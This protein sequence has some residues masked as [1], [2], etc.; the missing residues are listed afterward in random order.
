MNIYRERVSKIALAPYLSYA[1]GWVMRVWREE[2]V[3]TSD[4][5][6]TRPADDILRTI[7]RFVQMPVSQLELAK[8]ILALDRVNAVEIIDMAG[9]GEKLCRDVLTPPEL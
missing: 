6:R 5:W 3:T 2:P 7:D 8:A 1:T 9:F 4:P